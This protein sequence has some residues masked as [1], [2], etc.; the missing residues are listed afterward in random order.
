MLAFVLPMGPAVGR[1]ELPKCSKRECRFT[2]VGV[3]GEAVGTYESLTGTAW[4][5]LIFVYKL[6]LIW[7]F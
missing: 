7:N 6:Y 2:S 4:P 1:V 3:A 5:L